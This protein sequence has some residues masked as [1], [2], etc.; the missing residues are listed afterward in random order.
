MCPGTYDPITFGHLDIIVRARTLFDEVVIAIARNPHKVPLLPLEQRVELCEGA[1]QGLDNVR[2]EVVP[3]L[4]AQFCKDLRV[5]TIVKGLRG[6]VDFESETP[7]ALMNRKLAGVE[8]LF[9]PADGSLTHISSS[10]VKD[11]ARHGGPIDEFTTVEVA[12]AVRTAV[13][14]ERSH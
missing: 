5:A 9:L 3:G 4:L 10:L 13:D 6:G 14:A 1:I 11:V 7:M 8:T 2:V 12:H